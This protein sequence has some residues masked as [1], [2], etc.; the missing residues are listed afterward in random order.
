[1]KLIV[2][3]ISPCLALTSAA[4][5]KKFGRPYGGKTYRLGKGL[6]NNYKLNYRPL[7]RLGYGKRYGLRNRYRT[8]KSYGQKCKFLMNNR[9]L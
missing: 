1:M 4:Y 7:K 8:V 6:H 5:Y 3:L 9:H 2:V